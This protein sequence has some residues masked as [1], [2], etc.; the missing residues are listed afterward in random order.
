MESSAMGDGIGTPLIVADSGSFRA[1]FNR[2]SFAF[3]HGL[4][5]SP[6][7]G[8]PRLARLA[9]T[10]LA[11]GDQKKFLALGGETAV[12]GS[13]FESLPRQERLARTIE[14]LGYSH[15]WVK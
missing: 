14:D 4:Q 7:F 8:L 9:E 10:M 12:A 11:A 15:N 1:C 13:A 3:A 2:A 5:R 6:L